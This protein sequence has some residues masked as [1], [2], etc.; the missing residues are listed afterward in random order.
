MP[1][2]AAGPGI[3]NGLFDLCVRFLMWLADLCGMSYQAVNVW[4]FCVIWPAATVA[5]VGVVIWQRGRIRG[6]EQQME[7]KH[8]HMEE[9]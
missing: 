4:I 2:A 1:G 5:L 9:T 6:L 3:V 8:G 7:Q